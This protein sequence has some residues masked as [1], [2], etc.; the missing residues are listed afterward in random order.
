VRSHLDYDV[1]RGAADRMFDGVG[2]GFSDGK[3]NVGGGGG[4]DPC[5]R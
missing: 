2:R 4:I 5:G 1:T 3:Q